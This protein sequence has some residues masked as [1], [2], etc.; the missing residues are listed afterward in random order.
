MD[1]DYA[2]ALEWLEK[3]AD[4]GNATAMSNIGYFYKNGYGV[5][6]DYEKALEWYEKAADLGHEKSKE[7]AEE[8]RQQLQ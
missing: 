7:Y 8:I 3:A 6:Q 5:E 1:Q 2:K 4:L